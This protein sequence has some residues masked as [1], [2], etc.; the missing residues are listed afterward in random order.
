[1]LVGLGASNIMLFWSVIVAGEAF[2]YF[3]RSKEREFSLMQARLQVLKTQLQPH[4]LFNTL[5]A[6]SEL[7]H[8]DANRAEGTIS[9]LGDL[10]RLSLNTQ[11][12]QE[13][14]LRE[15][16]DFLRKYV[17]IQQTL[18][19]ERLIIHWNISPETLDAY[20]PNMILQPL[21]ENAIQ[22]G[23]A[24]R[25]SGGVVEIRAYRAKEKIILSVRD[26]GSGLESNAQSFG[27]DEAAGL[28]NVKARLQHLY[29]NSHELNLKTDGCGLYIEIQIPF[30]ENGVYRD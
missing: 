5:N 28:R 13:I 3:R 23:I 19:Q 1:M 15:E 10:L 26:D 25:V 29:G 2:R 14:T 20:I 22:H 4:F 9:Q 30:N 8:E 12:A 11:T 17:E 7:V 27:K 18:L 6:I 21:I 16:L 24:P